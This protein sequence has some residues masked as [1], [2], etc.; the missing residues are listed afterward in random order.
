MFMHIIKLFVCQVGENGIISR[1][2]TIQG[3]ATYRSQY[4]VLCDIP[5]PQSYAIKISSDRVSTSLNEALFVVYDS[6]CFTCQVGA[7][8]PDANCTTNVSPLFFPPVFRYFLLSFLYLF[9]LLPM[10]P[11]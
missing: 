10:S 9:I 11:L 7:S 3:A 1:G 8:S 5:L 6:Q 4:E 2:Q